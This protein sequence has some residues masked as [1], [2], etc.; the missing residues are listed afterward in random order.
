[1]AVRTRRKVDHRKYELWKADK[2]G[3]QGSRPFD[4][5][6]KQN[7][8]G[9][10]NGE[11]SNEKPIS[12]ASAGKNAKVDVSNKDEEP[13]VGEGDRERP[14][15]LLQPSRMLLGIRKKNVSDAK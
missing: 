2:Y 11:P 7:H 13:D 4:F 6:E 12:E 10:Y 3:S 8:G 1:M 9:S 5:D 14:P 15:V